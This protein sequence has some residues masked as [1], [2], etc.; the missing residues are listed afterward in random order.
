MAVAREVLLLSLVTLRPLRPF[1]SPA[2]DGP[3]VGGRALEVLPSNAPIVL[4]IE[5]DTALAELFVHV[6]ER[7][8][9]RIVVAPDIS[10]A[11]EMIRISPPLAAIIAEQFALDVHGRE[12]FDYARSLHPNL[13]CAVVAGIERGGS[14]ARVEQNDVVVLTK[15]VEP[16]SLQLLL[17]RARH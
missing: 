8:G 7:A 5:H 6:A 3:R 16:A 2:L 9:W 12:L 15:P 11:R 14:L 17:Q 1:D 10:S 13:T 4:L